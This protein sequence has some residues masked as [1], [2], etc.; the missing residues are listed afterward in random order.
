MQVSYLIKCRAELVCNTIKRLFGS[1][2]FVCLP[3]QF[4]ICKNKHKQEVVLSLAPLT[5]AA[6]LA[7]DVLQLLTCLHNALVIAAI[8][9]VDEALRVLEVMPP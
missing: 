2:I 9:H 7:Q 8:D 4:V 3:S 1:H 5:A 6:H